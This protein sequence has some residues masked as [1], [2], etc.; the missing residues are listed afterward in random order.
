MRGMDLTPEQLAAAEDFLNLLHHGGAASLR[1]H[2]VSVPFEQLVRLIARYG[3]VR[4]MAVAGGASVQ[5]PEGYVVNPKS[6]GEA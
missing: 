4:A 2:D 5:K 1:G 6:V 3:A